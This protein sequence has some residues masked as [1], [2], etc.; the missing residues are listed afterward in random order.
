MKHLSLC[1]LILLSACRATPHSF[2]IKDVRLFDGEE[3][4][5]E[6]TVL[7][8]GGRIAAVSRH[9]DLPTD[10]TVIDGH[11]KTLL[12]GLID[13]HTHA[14][15]EALSDA[16][17]FGVT[18]E[19]DMFTDA[20]WAAERR[21]EQK[22]HPVSDRADLFSAG[23]L[24]TATGGHGTEYGIKI[25]TLDA[26]EQAEAFVQARLDEGSDYIKI[27]VDDGAL[28]DLKLPTLDESTLR[29][30]ID[31]SHRHGSLAV[32][33]VM[34]KKVA[35]E[36]ISS[37]ADGLMHIFA[38]TPIDEELIQAA[39]RHKIFVVPTLCAIES[40]AGSS[41]GPA[42]SEDPQLA[43]F[44]SSEQQRNL[45]AA[46]PP[47][48][49]RHMKTALAEDAVR[50]LFRAGVPILAGTDAPNPGTA[51]GAGLHLELE[52]LV[53]AGLKALDALRAAT[54][55]PADAFHLPD[56]GRIAPGLKADLVLVD[57][58]PST[59]IAATRKIVGIWKDG[60]EVH[61]AAPKATEAPEKSPRL[62]PGLISD[63][64]KES[65]K[66][67]IGFGWAPSTDSMMGGT[68]VV[69]LKILQGEDG[70]RYL[71]VRGT[72][73]AGAPFPW[74]GPIF[75]PG[76]RPMAPV[77]GTDLSSLSFSAR[78]KGKLRILVFAESLGWIP[79]EY[80]FE[81]QSSW[82]KTTV[83]FSE[84]EGVDRSGLKAILFS[85]GPGLGDFEFDIDDV[86]FR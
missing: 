8:T 45:A 14:F 58:D 51:H 56:R 63:F 78:G 48:Y 65:L 24:V 57:G 77:D 17:R 9:L 25:P 81:L 47:S 2:A 82:T 55:I 80:Q 41:G 3:I 13:S 29:A 15:G 35:S 26:P 39:L 61:R 43:P 85:G 34:T 50:Q 46:F 70:G 84:F 28:Y 53:E 52:L 49:G 11:G 75:F 22:A 20:T 10:T 62:L 33:H 59:D 42:I 40:I 27:V 4:H 12:P 38:D 32:V 69:D 7:V 21:E 68:S 67:S 72:I 76:S 44:L 19:L 74:A 6:M 5:Q 1:V 37:G 64:E 36:A 54:S 73:D 79:V 86:R 60:V 23:T 16:L 66:T 18:T 71:Q 83:P 30:V 31:A